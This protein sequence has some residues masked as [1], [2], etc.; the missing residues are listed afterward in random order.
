MVMRAGVLY[1]SYDGM[2]EPLGQ[3]QVLAY[4]KRLSKDFKI[5]LISFEK[6]EDLRNKQQ[7]DPLPIEITASG[8]AWQSLK[9]HM[10]S[11]ALAMLWDIAIGTFLGLWL[12]MRHSPAVVYARSYVPSVIA[13][14]L[15]S[16][17]SVR[18]VFDMRG[19]WAAQ[20]QVAEKNLDYYLGISI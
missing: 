19:F 6:E 16:F 10:K 3:S 12:V 15:K 11:S 17:S 14:I 13:L 18:F 1:I 9:Y 4:Q 8:M 7:F 2:L 5:H 20:K